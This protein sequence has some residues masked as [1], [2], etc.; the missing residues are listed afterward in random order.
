[1][2]RKARRV[3]RAKAPSLTPKQAEALAVIRLLRQA[4]LETLE[5]LDRQELRVLGETGQAL[6]K[7][8]RDRLR[9]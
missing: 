4:V 7:R 8:N 5:I 9:G 1:M 6:S 3:S 2:P